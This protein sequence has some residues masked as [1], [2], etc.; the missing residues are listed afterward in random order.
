M[1]VYPQDPEAAAQFLLQQH[2][3]NGLLPINPG[4]AAQALGV[5]LRAISDAKSPAC[6]TYEEGKP[7]ITY[8]KDELL[9]RKRFA[10][11]H[12]LG[13]VVLQHT[14]HPAET[15]EHF[16]LNTPIRQE[17]EANEFAMS[18]LIPRKTLL[19]LIYSGKMCGTEELAAAH[20]VS[21]VAMNERISMLTTAG[22]LRL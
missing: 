22:I 3:N 12:A 13:H 16:S 6:L 8:D 2:W 10:V 7:V 5:Q 18:L 15:I 14:T 17:R 21:P 4:T 9:L 11:A 19:T 20:V 1:T